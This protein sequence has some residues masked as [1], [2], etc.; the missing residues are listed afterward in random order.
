[1]LE[2]FCV[3]VV[4]LCELGEVVW[5]DVWFVGFD[6]LGVVLVWLWMDVGVVEIDD[7]VWWWCGVC[8]FL[9]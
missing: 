8:G 6:D 2:L 4:V 9:V 5:C 7:G 1:M 3:D